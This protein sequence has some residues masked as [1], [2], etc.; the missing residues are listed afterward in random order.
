MALLLIGTAWVD[1]RPETKGTPPDAPQPAPGTVIAVEGLHCPGCAKKLTAKLK[2]VAGV[3]TAAANV[4][5]ALATV[6][7]KEAA[8]PS[9]R[10]M[11]EAVEEAGFK[12]TRIEGPGGTYT[13]KPPE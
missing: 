7:P 4:K 1:A 12:P 9:P 5:T 13:A 2:A 3:A 6:T 10:A 11:W 8:K